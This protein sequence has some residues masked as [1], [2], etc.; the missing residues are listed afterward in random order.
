MPACAASPPRFPEPLASLLVCRRFDGCQHFVRDRPVMPTWTDEPIASF[1]DGL[2]VIDVSRARIW[3]F[4]ST[5][6]S[7][8]SPNGDDTSGIAASGSRPGMANPHLP[9]YFSSGMR[10]IDRQLQMIQ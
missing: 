10:R 8:L 1:I 2:E 3:N 7:G 5:P 9:C 6:D 4:R